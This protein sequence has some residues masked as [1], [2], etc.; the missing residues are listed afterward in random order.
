LAAS[1]L[2]F[3]AAFIFF[4]FSSFLAAPMPSSSSCLS[5]QPMEFL[6]SFLIYL[7]FYLI[8]SNLIPASNYWC[9]LHSVVEQRCG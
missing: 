8:S 9:G 7:L 5:Y 2:L 3:P 4:Y 1:I 6:L